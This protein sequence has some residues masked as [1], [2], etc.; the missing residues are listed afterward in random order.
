MSRVLLVLHGQNYGPDYNPYLD[1]SVGTPIVSLLADGTSSNGRNIAT[2]DVADD[3]QYWWIVRS[4][5]WIMLTLYNDYGDNTTTI[6]ATQNV[7][8]SPRNGTVTFKSTGCD[9]VVIIVTQ[10]GDI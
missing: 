8:E 2:V 1:V 7:S 3:D 9:D 10:E 6:T 4:D 5:T